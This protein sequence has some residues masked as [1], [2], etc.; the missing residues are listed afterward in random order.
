MAVDGTPTE[1]VGDLQE[2]LTSQRIGRE[3]TLTYVRGGEVL[4][5]RARPDELDER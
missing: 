1:Q 3:V 5:G 4:H 2:L